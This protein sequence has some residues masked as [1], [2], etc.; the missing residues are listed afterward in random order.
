MIQWGESSGTSGCFGRCFVTDSLYWQHVCSDSQN[1]SCF[2]YS[3]CAEGAQERNEGHHPLPLRQVADSRTHLLTQPTCFRSLFSTRLPSNAG[4]Q[5]SMTGWRWSCQCLLNP[6]KYLTMTD[7]TN[8]AAILL[9]NCAIQVPQAATYNKH[10]SSS[11]KICNKT[12]RL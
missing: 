4:R 11:S 2:P 5:T 6:A 12:C 9:R 3:G 8:I 10:I 1:V 7:C